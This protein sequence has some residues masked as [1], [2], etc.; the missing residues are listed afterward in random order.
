MKRSGTMGVDNV[1]AFIT[2]GNS[3]MNSFN[4]TKAAIFPHAGYASFGLFNK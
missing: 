1:A 3:F 4:K 2:N